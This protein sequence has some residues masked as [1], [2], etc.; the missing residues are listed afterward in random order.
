MEVWL[1]LILSGF[2]VLTLIALVKHCVMNKETPKELQEKFK[3][4]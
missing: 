3:D 4:L 1:Y 2:A